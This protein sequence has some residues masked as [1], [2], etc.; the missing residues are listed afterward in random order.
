MDGVCQPCR[1]GVLM[2][3]SGKIYDSGS[4]WGSEEV[5][6]STGDRPAT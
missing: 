1:V 3:E 2:E 6:C 5:L 4:Q